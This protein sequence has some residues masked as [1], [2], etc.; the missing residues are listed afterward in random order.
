MRI[1]V[2]ATVDADMYGGGYFEPISTHFT[3]TEAERF[4]E[5]EGS[6]DIVEIEVHLSE[7]AEFVGDRDRDALIAIDG[8]MNRLQTAEDKVAEA[9]SAQREAERKTSDAEEIANH[10]HARAQ[11]LRKDRDE[12]MQENNQLRNTIKSLRHKIS[13]ESVGKHF[14]GFQDSTGRVWLPVKNSKSLFGSPGCLNQSAGFIKDVL[15]GVPYYK[16]VK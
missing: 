9:A 3:R 14:V 10:Q 2:R 12:I 5:S 15:G 11:D 4:N 13:T 6:L 8:M 7:L 16:E 1:F